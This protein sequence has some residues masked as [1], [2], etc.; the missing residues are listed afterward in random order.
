M[1]NAFSRLVLLLASVVLLATGCTKDELVIEDNTAPPDSTIS[2]LVIEN[3][4]TKCYISLLG[5]EPNSQEESDAIATLKNDNMSLGS[6]KSVLGDITA[7]DEYFD[8][9]LEFN[10]L[11][12]INSPFDTIAIQEQL[13]VAQ[14]IILDP[15]YA[16]FIDIIQ[17]LIDDFEVLLTTPSQFRNGTIGMEEMHRRLVSNDIYDQINM[18]SFNFVLSM[19]NNFLFRDPTGDEH[20]AGI[21]MVDGFVAVFFFETANNK[22]DFIDIFLHSADYYEGQVRELYFRYLFRE[23][24]SAEQGY[25]SVRYKESSDY[26]R[27]QVD[28]LSTDEFAGL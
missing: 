20:N 1:N 7:N 13:V 22:D 8:K 25:H 4:V 17:G 12:L 28:I 18:G 2:T 23:P 10:A 5:R 14:L 15:Q 16:P 26:A 24:T 9:V 19:F 27:L 21:T 6:R 11:K 3:Y